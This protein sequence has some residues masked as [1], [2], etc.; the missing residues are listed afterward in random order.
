MSSPTQFRRAVEAVITR[1][2]PR[3]ETAREIHE[4]ETAKLRARMR[5]EDA[6]A[7]MEQERFDEAFDGHG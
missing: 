7:A 5:E 6:G 3:V 2:L 4:T 1:T